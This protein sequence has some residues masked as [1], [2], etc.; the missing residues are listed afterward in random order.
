[1]GEKETS[2]SFNENK[3][4]PGTNPAWGRELPKGAYNEVQDAGGV[5]WD[6]GFNF[7]DYKSK[8]DLKDEEKPSSRPEHY[9]RD[10]SKKAI[11]A[12]EN[13]RRKSA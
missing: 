11:E 10:L 8:E 12:A 4:I 1:M 13:E 6:N 5:D 7:P 2:M 9:W 3:F